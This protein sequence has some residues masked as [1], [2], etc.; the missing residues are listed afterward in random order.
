MD[1]STNSELKR[2]LKESNDLTDLIVNRATCESE[3]INYL[4]CMAKNRNMLAKCLQDMERIRIC[5][6]NLR[7]PPPK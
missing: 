4:E 6:A 1:S 5:N 7:A 3:R 2:Q